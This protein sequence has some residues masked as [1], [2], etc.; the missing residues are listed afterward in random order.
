[1]SVGKMENELLYRHEPRL[2]VVF[3]T[4]QFLRENS[5]RVLQAEHIIVYYCILMRYRK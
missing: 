2:E 1:M 4:G 3:A 5:V